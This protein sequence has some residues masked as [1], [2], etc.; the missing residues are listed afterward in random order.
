MRCFSACSHLM[1]LHKPI[2]IWLLLWPTLWALWLAN[3]QKM[4]SLKLLIVFICGVILM[5]SAGCVINDIMD[6]DIDGFVVRT[7]ERPL[8]TGEISVR[9]AWILFSCLSTLACALVLMLNGFT[10][11]LAII[12]FILACFYP[13]AKRY[14]P[15]PQCI[16]G[17]AFAWGIPMA[18][19][20]INGYVPS[21]AWLLFIATYLW[22]VAY[23]TQYAIADRDDDTK[24]GIQSTAI[25][26]GNYD[27]AWIMALQLVMLLFLT[28]IGIIID[29]NRIFFIALL[30]SFLCFVYQ[31]WLIRGNEPQRCLKAF[32]SNQWVG[33]LIF[34]GISCS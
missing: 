30:L 15:V 26:F 24:I 2:G 13:L 14:C 8:V 18:F 16:L 25:H 34:L 5:R 32:T 4:P 12:G 31:K 21:I 19:S 29:A 17:F 20:A 27:H 10:I 6:R 1:R 3:H 9:A 7:R 11:F 28:M 33:A 22:I 23:D